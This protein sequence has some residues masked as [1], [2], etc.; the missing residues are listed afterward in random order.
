M[1]TALMPETAA[2]GEERGVCPVPMGW[3]LLV[4]AVLRTLSLPLNK[5]IKM[6]LARGI[7]ITGVASIGLKEKGG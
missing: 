1:T 3:T 2:E 7:D 5:K 6:Q 4:L